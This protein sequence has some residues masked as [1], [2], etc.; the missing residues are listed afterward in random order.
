MLIMNY[1]DDDSDTDGTSDYLDRDFPPVLED[2][3][4]YAVT[5]SRL[6]FMLK[7]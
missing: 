2:V 1:A 7:L 5:A 4:F 3:S 6:E